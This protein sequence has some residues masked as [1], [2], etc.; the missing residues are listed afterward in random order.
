M[1]QY[2]ERQAQK[3]G[4]ARYCVVCNTTK[5]NR[6]NSGKVCG[7]CLAMRETESKSSLMGMLSRVELEPA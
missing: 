1:V 5:L 2:H 4:E 3:R 6:Y 7:G